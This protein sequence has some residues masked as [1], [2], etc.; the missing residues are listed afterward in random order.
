MIILKHLT[1]ER[2]RLLR[3]VNLHFPQRGSILIQGPNEAGKSALL[4]S[5]YFALYGEPLCLPIATDQSKRSLDDLISYGA[6]SAT[7][8]L[9]LAIGVTELSVTRIL[10]RGKGQKVSLYVRKLSMPEEGPITRLTT[11]NERIIAELGRIDGEALRNS[12]LIEQKGSERLE[13]LNGVTREATIRRIL[14][15]EQLLRV[16]EHFKVTSNDERLLVEAKERLRLA[17][18]QERI[19]E[20][21]AHFE[22]LEAALDGVTVNEELAEVQQQQVELVEQEQAIEQLHA[23]RHELKNRLGQVQQLKV[24]DAT[25]SEIITAYEEIA[26]A[27]QEIPVLEKQIADLERRECEELPPLEQ[28]VTELSDLTRSF[29]TLQRMSND[30]LAGVDTIKELEQDLQYQKE[31]SEDLASLQEQVAQAEE[32]VQQAKLA[33]QKLEERRRAGRPMLET[34]LQRLRTLSERLTALKSLEDRYVQHLKS[35]AQA[36]ENAEK[37]RQLQR[38]QAETERKLKLVE[39]EAERIQQEA[40]ALD[41]R[42][43]QLSI[44]HQIEEWQR[45]KGLAQGLAQAE[46]HVHAAYQQQE[47]LTQA[48]QAVGKTVRTNLILITVCITLFVFCAIATL[49]GLINHSMLQA[50]G[51][52]ILALL[53]AAGAGLSLQN[54]TKARTEKQAIDQQKQDAMNRMGMMVTAREAARRMGGSQE[55]LM[56]VEREIQN[57]GGSVPRSLEEA[58]HQLGQIAASDES[59]PDIQK[60][61]KEKRDEVNTARNQVNV[62]MGAAES[63]RKERERLEK[64]RAREGWNSLDEELRSDLAAI[65]RVHQEIRLLAGQEGLPKSSVDERLQRSSV[66]TQGAISSIPFTPVLPIEGSSE[67][68]WGTPW[69]SIPD[70]ESLIATTMKATEHEI[71]SLD[72]KLDL[73]ADLTR[74]LKTRQEA[75]DVLLNRKRAIE[76]RNERY[77]TSNPLQQIERA[78]EQQVML[79]GAMQSLQ[80]S[81]R[82]RVK[83]LGIPFGQ[84]AISAAETA[85][86]KQLEELHIALAGKLKLQKQKEQYGT[87][88]KE[89]QE[90]LAEH[91]K[92]LARISNSLGSWIVP[93]NPFAEALVAL[94]TRCQREIEKANERG[95][96]KELDDLQFQEGALRAKIELCRQ[97]IENAHERIATLLM[98]RHRPNPRSYSR[99]DLIAVWPLI[100]KYTP[101][102]RHHLEEERAQVEEELTRVE[103]QELVLSQQ[104]HT[105]GDRLDLDLARLRMEQQERSYQTKKYGNAL[106]KAVSERL[107]R[108]V[109]PRTEYYMQQLLPLLTSGRY[110]DIHLFTEQEEGTSSGGPLHLRVWDSTAGEYVAK[111]ALS[112]GTADQLSLALRLAFAIATLPRELSGAPGFLILDEP[113]SSLDRRRTQALVDVIAGSLVSQ[114]FEQVILVSQSSAFDPAM[115]PYH[116]YLDN[117]LVV[118]SN[119]PLVQ[120]TALPGSANAVVSSHIPDD[121]EYDGGETVHIA[122]IPVL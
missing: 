35:R 17:E 16:A 29:G 75:L 56:R 27:Q 65:E 114:H 45:L 109:I 98:Q 64:Q 15:I 2:F 25:L 78:H 74:Q 60:R 49:L 50:A 76:E 112:G 47:Q 38:E 28:R 79:R 117:G 54:Y 120:S 83:P 106:V 87:L 111:A 116:I 12:C 82:Q 33:L 72:D 39:T 51:A 68:V 73:V 92:Q 119:L 122:A 52:G 36:L 110:H 61:A 113:L 115:F 59:I 62:T 46:Q 30:L 58:A 37:L 31:A 100:G 91:Y 69:S 10:E 24:A 89:Q 14:G 4:E 26:H 9:I 70:L 88:L 55:D 57:L 121:D 103:E 41:R 6:T 21:S 84:A 66:A 18:L 40:E 32:Q 71:A 94:R 34:R 48:E 99:E 77:Q 85:A 7:V 101:Q 80:D 81:L 107:V 63:L 104:L 93:L 20:L 90:S 53:L 23:R 96:L 44:R 11:A 86:R 3:E 13:K 22:E 97:E 102:D 8:T 19:P 5:I 67:G 105:G 43:R 95:M 118:E 108:K 1:V 42:W